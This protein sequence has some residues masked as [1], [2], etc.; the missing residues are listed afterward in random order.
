MQTAT[1]FLVM[2]LSINSISSENSCDKM[3]T[4]IY[5]D[6]GC[7]A[8]N[9]EGQT[10]PERFRCDFTK[11]NA[12]SC[13]F[14][15]KEYFDGE[16]IEE[17]LAEASCNVRCTCKNGTFGCHP[18]GLCRKTFEPNAIFCYSKRQLGMCCPTEVVCPPFAHDAF[19]CQV[20]GER[21]NVGE[22][23]TPK[24][25]CL[26]CICRENFTGEFDEV[27]CARQNC[28]AQ[29][30]E[31]N[32]IEQGCAPAYFQPAPS[33]LFYVP[34][35]KVGY[36][37]VYK[38]FLN[39]DTLCCPDDWICP[40]PLDN[41]TVIE[42]ERGIYSDLECKYGNKTFKFGEGFKQRIY[43]YRKSRHMKSIDVVI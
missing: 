7:T 35:N 28:A 2:L 6:I 4:L 20:D 42:N 18:R 21:Y 22:E 27:S 9:I 12:S 3:G 17:H 25:T 29:L 30:H 1:L 16:A 24:N 39:T 11:L 33:D 8:I 13:L 19:Q 23:F 5:E 40:Q 36:V 37:A 32:A 41:V 14:K 34:P 26:I 38:K 31:T 15:G 43:R 10:C